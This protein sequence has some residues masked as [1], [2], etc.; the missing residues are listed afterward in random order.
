MMKAVYGDRFFYILY[1]QPVG[2]AEAELERDPRLTM[3]RVLYGASGDGFGGTAGRAP[4]RGRHRLPR[5]RCPTRPSHC[6]AWL[7]WDDIDRYAEGFR[8][9]GFF[10]PLSY[11]RN[12]DADYALVK[13]LPADRIAMPS[14]FIGGDRDVVVASNPGA[15]D[16][17]QAA[18]PDFRV[19]CCCQAS[20]TG[21]SRRR[22]ETLRRGAMPRLP[23]R[24]RAS[25][26]RAG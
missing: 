21:P 11:Y 24:P 14:F 12:L 22:R 19:P 6:P 7:T 16:A 25:S 9:S 3:A 15:V 20:G 18:L 5:P 8:A 26:S 2:P 17:M 10:G 23:R 4:A 13:D 1:F